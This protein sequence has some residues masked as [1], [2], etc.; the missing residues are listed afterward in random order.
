MREAYNNMT[1]K[2]ELSIL[3]KSPFILIFLGILS[4]GVIIGIMPIQESLAQEDSSQ[5]K[6]NE[7]LVMSFINDVYVDRNAS[8]IDKYLADNFIAN[9]MDDRSVD[10]ESVK[11]N[12]SAFINAFPDLVGTTEHIIADEDMV[13]IFSKWNGTFTEDYF[14][15]P[16]NDNSITIAVADIF[17]I[18]DGQIVESWQIG[19]YSNLTKTIH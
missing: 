2:K 18:S 3:G 6:D 14:D 7:E 13:V 19:D 8:A 10:G 17:R 1:T 16:A 5:E 12:I 11:G 4:V 9:F 15:T